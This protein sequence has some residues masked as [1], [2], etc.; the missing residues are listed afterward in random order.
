MKFSNS[1][2]MPAKLESGSPGD[3]EMLAMI[4]CKVTYLVEHGQLVTASPA[5]SWPVFD[6]PFVYQQVTLGP[7]LEFR[8]EAVDLIVFGRALAPGGQRIDRMMVAV[9]CGAIDYR[10]LVTGDRLWL[11]S[12]GRLVASTPVP[13][14]EM[15]LT[16]DRAYGGAG[17]VEGAEIPHAVNPHGRGFYMD[18]ASAAH[19]PL[20]NL[21]LPDAPVAHWSD[22]PAPACFYRP[23]GWSG[24]LSIPEGADPAQLAQ[25]AMAEMMQQS[26]PAL[27]CAPEQLGSTIRVVGMTIEG[28]TSLPAPP[29]HG[30]VA[31]ARVGQ[32]RGRFPSTI[33][34]IVVLV[35]EQVVI[36]TY[37]CLFR[38]LF[39][40]MDER[41]VE[42]L[43]P[44]PGAAA[45]GPAAPLLESAR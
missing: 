34:S 4:A 23:A 17:L 9:Q 37:L 18:A 40:P 13:F 32:L 29:L 21:E 35:D 41:A 44:A 28:D 2:G 16:S 39:R 10:V 43:W 42:L 38:Y 15:P 7:D 26:V 1:T 45:H 8:R 14:L 25:R 3:T 30:P 27:T 6:A 5:D 24:A 12:A 36:A 22:A 20:P 11:P 19:S 33:S 31:D